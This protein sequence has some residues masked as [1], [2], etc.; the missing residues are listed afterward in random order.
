MTT[1][2]PGAA[3]LDPAGAV[4]A[5]DP[6]FAALLGL[7]PGDPTAALRA[8][9]GDAP[10]L[11]ALLAGDGAPAV[12]VPGPAGEV[13]VERVPAGAGALLLARPLRAAEWLEHAMRSQGLARLA[14]GLAHDVKNPLNAMALQLALLAEKLSGAGDAAAAAAPHLAALRDQIGK[15]NAVVRRFLDVADPSAPL[16]DTDAGTL[17]ADTAGLLAHEARRRSIALAVD[18][19]RGAVR[20]RCDPA[21][22][23]RL[24]LGLLTRAL[25]ETPDGGRVAAH[26]AG[27]GQGVQV[28]I[29]HAAGA[30]DPETG[31]YSE[32]AT[33]AARALGGSLSVAREGGEERILLRLPGNGHG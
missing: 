11:R 14:A 10:A 1:H 7:A 29:A 8:R 28:G 26:A 12:V 16:G 31:Y 32:V 18:A 3:F 4:V 17:L 13:E 19:P 33:A 15:V 2:L 23:G 5:A 9:A 24:V 25:A 6:A 21:R 27:D 30:P 20:T 22:L